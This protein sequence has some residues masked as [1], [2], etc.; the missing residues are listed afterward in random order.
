MHACVDVDVRVVVGV[1]TAALD[2]W[3]L[4]AMLHCQAG[5]TYKTYLA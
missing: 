2:W 5:T 4:I 3:K 1:T